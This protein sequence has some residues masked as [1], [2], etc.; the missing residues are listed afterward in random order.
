MRLMQFCQDLYP[1]CRSIT[2]NGVRDT[3][4]YIKNIHPD[5]NIIE[6]PSGT[7]AFDWEVPAEWNI[8][9]A[10]VADEN[11]KKIID[12]KNHNLHVVG[13]STPINE[14]M[15]FSELDKHLHSL[16]QNPDAIP[17][18]TSVY[19]KR[20]GFCITEEQRNKLR[21]TPE[22][23]YHV[24][25][26]SSLEPGFLTYGELVIKGE[27][28]REILLS[29]YVCHP[30]MANNELSGPCVTTF[31]A[32][33]LKEQSKLKYT[34]RILFLVETIG[35][36]VYL[37][38]HL[39]HLKSHVD[40]GF[41]LTCVGDDN[42]FSYMP[43]RNG[44]TLADRAAKITL[45]YQYPA[46]K[47][48]SYLDRGSDERQFC[49]PLVDLPVCSITRSLYGRYNE[50]HTSLDDLNFISEQ[51][52]SLSVDMY[53]KVISLLEKN[54]YYVVSTY[55]EPM[56]SKYNIYNTLST[57]FID[58]QTKLMRNIIGYA[59]GKLD[60]IELCEKLN[61]NPEDICILIKK[62]LKAGIIQET[63]EKNW[64]NALEPVNVPC[65]E[66]KK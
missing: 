33:W 18:V 49:A 3:L 16:P 62:L 17:Y 58:K 55:C 63:N 19:E 56:L 47:A 14:A 31:L 60:L 29:T 41:V 11:G 38:K 51:G 37:S 45:K 65:T 39:R 2:G 1:I 36:I 7:K 34:Y 64:V 8:N 43:S 57:G 26:D 6:V 42:T 53:K 13:Y 35:S 32:K 46:Y 27:T 4:S 48:Y 61:A 21:K 22:K 44:N 15:S 23:K 10:Y 30:S 25:I 40:A 59:D 20:W 12:F 5:L 52:L 9:D 28:N 50:Y 54:K 24:K 66:D